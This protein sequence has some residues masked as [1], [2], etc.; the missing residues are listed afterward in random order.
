M[1][2]KC[3]DAKHT[4]ISLED[5][6]PAGFASSPPGS[7]PQECHSSTEH[8]L[9]PGIKRR[10]FL[11]IHRKSI[12]CPL[13]AAEG[14]PQISLKKQPPLASNLSMFI[15]CGEGT[16]PIPQDGMKPSLLTLGTGSTFKPASSDEG[17]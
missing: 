9:W 11:S 8:F 17:S 5:H 16:H 4:G 7:H 10:H 3:K 2:G 15:S 6:V 13:P 1:R 12:C 14:W